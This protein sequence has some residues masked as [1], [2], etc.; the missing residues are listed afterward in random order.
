MPGR[1]AAQRVRRCAAA[2]A[3]ALA[4]LAACGGGASGGSTVHVLYAGSLVNLMEKH[5]GPGFSRV[6]G[7]GYQGYGAASQAAANAIRGKLRSGDVFISASPSVDTALTGATNGGW[8][9]WYATFATAPLVLGYSPRSRYAAALRT[10]PWYRV[11]RQPGIRVGM[12]D[13]TLDPKGK[14][15]VAA[16]DAAQR[17]YRLPAGF[18]AAVRARTTVFPE[19]DLVGRLEAGQLDVGFFYTNEATPAHIPTVS[20]G[21]VHEAATFTVTVLERAP[22]PAGGAS[23]VH[24]LLT[25]A[26][27]TLTAGG[28]RL[29]SPVLIGS[30]AAVPPSLR[31]LLAG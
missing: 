17:T 13:P 27:P 12:T 7:S 15:T 2:A 4:T 8:V 3:A 14:L 29:Q 25:S 16:L 23:F 31:A 19:Q 22:D 5:V 21:R 28:L 10:R 18:A 24:Y 26:R 11:I 6:T 20:L 30:R 1:S 9:R